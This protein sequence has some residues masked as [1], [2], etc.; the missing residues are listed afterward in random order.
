MYKDYECE[1]GNIIEYRKE[2][3]VDFP[4]TIKCDLCGKDMKKKIGKGSSGA[5]I[6]PEYMKSALGYKY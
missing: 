6:I 2:Y 3:K 4:E 5:I 1:C